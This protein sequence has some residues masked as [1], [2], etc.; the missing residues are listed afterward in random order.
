[1]LNSTVTALAPSVT[2]YGAYV[3]QDAPGQYDQSCIA[4]YIPSTTQCA[5]QGDTAVSHGLSVED[6]QL[7]AAL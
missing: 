5:K 6:V 2:G 1:M 7:L 4:P 3:G